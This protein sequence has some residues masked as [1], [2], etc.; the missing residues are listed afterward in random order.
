MKWKWNN[1]GVIPPDRDAVLGILRK[2]VPEVAS[3]A[4]SVVNTSC[5]LEVLK[6]AYHLHENVTGEVRLLSGGQLTQA[7]VELGVERIQEVQWSSDTRTMIL[8]SLEPA[9]VENVCLYDLPRRAVV[10][11]APDQLSCVVGTRGQNVALTSQ[12]CGWDLDVMTA[13]EFVEQK[14]FAFAKL[15][16]LAGTTESTGQRLVDAGYFSLEDVAAMNPLDLQQIVPVSDSDAM[17][18]IR[19]ARIRT[20][21]H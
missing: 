4:I 9:H 16:T 17:V 7:C 10:T 12:L 8:R 2:L 21:G 13:D 15:A 3:G 1:F 5:D 14:R 11:V 20:D 6:I 19:E 18:I